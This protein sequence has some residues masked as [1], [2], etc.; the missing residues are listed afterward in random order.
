MSNKLFQLQCQKGGHIFYYQ[1]GRGDAPMT[2]WDDGMLRQQVSHDVSFCP[3]CG[4]RKVELTGRTY[5]A[6]NETKPAGRRSRRS[7]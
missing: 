4:S 6:V 7:R 1:H 2:A 3:I 5:K